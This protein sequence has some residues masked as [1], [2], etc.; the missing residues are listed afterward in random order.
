MK[1][2]DYLL[3]E[4]TPIWESYYSHPFIAEIG[5]G[6]LPKEKF[7]FYIVQDYIYLLD[8]AKVFALGVV[9]AREED[10][11]QEFSKLLDGILNS[12]MGTHRHYVK[13]LGITSEEVAK[14]K[15]SLANTSYTKYMLAEAFTGGMAE[16][17]VALLACSWSYYLIGLHL[18][19]I[20]GAKDDP[21]YGN[22][23]QTYSGEA[24]NQMN[25]WLLDLTNK[26]CENLD[27]FQK[28]KL[29][30]IFINT[31][32]YEYMFWDMSYKMEF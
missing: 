26:Y 29:L 21:F 3:K 24:Y 28:E 7:R 32:K 27:S 5:K 13:E 11:M 6:T 18:A 16:I 9:K 25:D 19:S 14:T 31:S 30:E 20:P 10:T 23:I 2:T 1:F 17:T 22:W 15:A 4:V 8:Y 12:E